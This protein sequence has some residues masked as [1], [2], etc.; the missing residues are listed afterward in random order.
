M[1][2]EAPYRVPAQLDFRLVES[3]LAA[4]ASAAEDHLWAL[5]EDPG[6]FCRTLLETKEHSR[7]MLKDLDGN[8]HPLLTHCREESLWARIIRFI[9]TEA[10]F[11]LEN[12]SGL[13][14][15]AKKLA[16]LQRQYADDIS[17]SKDLPEEY[18]G[19]MLQFNHNLER[20]I[21]AQLA[22]L[23]C[24]AAASLPLRRFFARVPPPSPDSKIVVVP[25][26]GID[27]DKV[28]QQLIWL[29]R[30]LW[31]NGDELLL[32]GLPV[33]M[34]ELERLIQSETHAQDLLS[35]YIITVV[36]KL[37]ILSQC[38]NELI[39]QPAPETGSLKLKSVPTILNRSIR[40][41]RSQWPASQLPFTR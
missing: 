39:F 22:K 3:L 12:I 37:S 7:L 38:Y 34:D 14:S 29:L 18:L 6:Y 10:Y 20:S 36:G 23:R 15:Q 30:T 2:V 11:E 32:A 21:D 35:S 19:A 25:K 8:D 40:S 27:M 28:E 26:P 17:P 1:A 13:S 4:G 41:R 24:A 5:R 16:S 9:V 33:V 31:E